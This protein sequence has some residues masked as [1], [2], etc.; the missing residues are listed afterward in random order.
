M[1]QPKDRQCVYIDLKYFGYQLRA[2]VG[3]DKEY[4]PAFTCDQTDRGP[5]GF[6]VPPTLPQ[7]CCLV[8]MCVCTGMHYA[9]L[10]AT[11]RRTC[12]HV[13]ELEYRQRYWNELAIIYALEYWYC[14]NTICVHIPVTHVRNLMTIYDALLSHN[15]LCCDV[16]V[17]FFCFTFLSSA[18]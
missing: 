14:Y 5:A 3:R 4:P 1:T 9:C 18:E 16:A 2:L 17:F 13:Y 12:A 6:I 10:H 8:C 7:T 11:G 15:S